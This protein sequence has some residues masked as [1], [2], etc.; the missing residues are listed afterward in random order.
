MLNQK[1]Y[2]ATTILAKKKLLVIT[3][4]C[5]SKVFVFI[6]AI[7]FTI[8]FKFFTFF[9]YFPKPHLPKSAPALLVF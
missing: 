5:L 9:F 2:N 7:I 3:M 1:Y 6:S 8:F 4:W